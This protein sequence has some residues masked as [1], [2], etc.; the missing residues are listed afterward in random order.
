MTFLERLRSMF[1]LGQA[2]GSLATITRKQVIMADD[3][4]RLERLGDVE[5]Q[6]ERAQKFA[7]KLE[8]EVATARRAEA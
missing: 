4:E 1:R 5:G 6:T 3:K 7:A 8:S 2:T